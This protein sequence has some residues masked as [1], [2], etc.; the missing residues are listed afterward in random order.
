MSRQLASELLKLRTTKT[1][2]ALIGTLL[3]LCVLISV[4]ATFTVEES[5]ENFNS[6]DLLGISGFS[7]LIALVLGLLAVT[8]EIRHGTITPTLV[9]Q[10][11]RF[12]VMAAKLVSHVLAGIVL[13]GVAVAAVTAIVLLGLSARDI[14]TGLDSGDVTKIVVGQIVA[15]GLWA[16]I[17]VGFGAL[18]FNQVGAIVGALAWTFLVENLLTLIPTFGDW[19][20]KYG[21]NGASNGLGNLES[22]NTGDVLGQVPAGL[23]LLAYAAAF[24]IAG[25]IMLRRRDITS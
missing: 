22:E 3:G 18:V 19:V 6:V 25:A 15:G 4:I 17:G 20:Q 1:A 13:A 16:A 8:T 12:T 21:I 11:N 24:V 14:D 9:A 2:I 10:P 5:D 23:L 7:Q